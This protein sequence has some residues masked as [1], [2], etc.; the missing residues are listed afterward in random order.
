MI[1][2]Y[3]I[4]G[5][6]SNPYHAM[7]LI[8][9]LPFP[10]TVL[11]LPGHGQAYQ[12]HLSDL[13]QLHSWFESKVPTNEP[14]VLIGH[15]LGGMLASYLTAHYK[16]A[17]QLVLLDGG[18]FQ[19]DQLVSLQEEWEGTKA[20]LEGQVFQDPDQFLAQEKAGA[21]YWSSHLEI[22]ALSNYQQEEDGLWHLRL[23]PTALKDLLLLQ[24]LCQGSLSQVTCP[25]LLLPQTLDCPSWKE[26]MLDSLPDSISI[27]KIAG[28]GHSP[29]TDKPTAVAQA[30]VDFLGWI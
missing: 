13:E 15:S 23:N 6:G 18:Y 3:F 30:I 27:K 24:R 10:V 5:L 16:T 1:P 28:V 25:V 26:E 22:A 8:E 2:T 21:S 7:D 20:Y 4:G 29:H 12:T 17:R 19:L 11:D 14:F 9:N